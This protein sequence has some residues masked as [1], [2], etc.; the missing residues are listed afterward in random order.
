[1]R[2]TDFTNHAFRVLVYLAV[3][4]RRLATIGEIAESYGISGSH[5]NKVAWELGRAGFI[6]TVRG[7]GGGLK[8]A[9]PAEALPLGAVARRTER[10]ILFAECSPGEAGAC[11]IAS[12]C[13]LKNVLSE[14]EEAFF[15]VLD[16]YS[17]QDLVDHNHGLRPILL[18]A[19]P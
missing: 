1:M 18:A 6:D 2:L 9:R 13:E 12:C 7:K 8:L 16:R 17:I 14:A 11:R 15:A 19:R 3:N 4:N 5:L 10:S